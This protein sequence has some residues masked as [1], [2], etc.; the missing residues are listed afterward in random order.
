MPTTPSYGTIPAQVLSGF[1]K[2]VNEYGLTGTLIKANADAS[3]GIAGLAT[4][5]RNLAPSNFV[6]VAQFLNLVANSILVGGN[7]GIYT[8]TNI[9][10]LTTAI[11]AVAGFEGFVTA[12]DSNLSATFD[13]GSVLAT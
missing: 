9:N 4:T 6:G 7:I 1:N 5:I 3:G 10:S 2:V 8:D 13:T 11:T 12:F